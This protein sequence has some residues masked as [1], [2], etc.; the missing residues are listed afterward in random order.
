MAEDLFRFAD[1][2]G[3]EKIVHLHHPGLGLKAIVVVDNTAAGPAIGGTRMAADVS[4]EE[5]FRLARAMT[6]K[7][8]AAGL[9]HGGA[10][11]VIVA[12]PA[13]PA[14][15]KEQVIRAFAVAIRELADYIPGPDMGTDETAMAWI[16]DEIGRAV[17]LPREIGGIPLDEIG[18]TGFG[19]SIAAEVA[20]AFC[21]VSL[22]GAQVAIQGFGAVGKHAARFLTRQG[23]VLVAASDSRGA[24]VNPDGL[25]VAALVAHKEAGEPIAAFAGGRALAGDAIVGVACDI[26]IPAARPDVLRADNVDRLDC[27]MVL[28]GANIPATVEAEERLHARGILVVP[29]FIANAGGVI[30]AAVEHAGGTQAAAFAVIEEKL[31][32]NTA[33]VLRRA[34]DEDLKPREAAVL[35]AGERV[36][37]AMSLRRWGRAR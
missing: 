1:G 16:R 18:A 6:F 12:D 31:R 5:C 26:W 32:A 2:Y 37:T 13:M 8:A 14:A 20:Q 35:L 36:R 17:G 4:V 27:R 28:Q 25:D 23:A 11:S 30:C 15:D 33:A 22:N 21:G 9:S 3:P 24:T 19:L 29:D 7:N 10:K 34:R